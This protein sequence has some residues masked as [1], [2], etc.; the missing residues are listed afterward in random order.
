[1]TTSLVVLKAA[2]EFIASVKEHR[3]D[4]LY[5]NFRCVVFLNM[6]FKS[7]TLRQFYGRLQLS[8]PAKLSFKLTNI[9]ETDGTF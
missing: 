4:V 8:R 9:R 5:A 2:R 1:M 3:H 6:Y 7:R